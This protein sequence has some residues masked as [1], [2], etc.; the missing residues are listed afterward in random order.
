MTLYSNITNNYSSRMLR[1]QLM[2]MVDFLDTCRQGAKL[3]EEINKRGMYL[4]EGSEMF[5][6]RDLRETK[7]G[8]LQ[9]FLS[10]QVRRLAEHIK[11]KCVTCSARG[12]VCEICSDDK[13]IYAFEILKASACQGCK[14]FFHRECIK[15]AT[16]CPRCRRL[17]KRH[18]E[19][20]K[21]ISNANSTSGQMF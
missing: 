6:M 19:S 8:Q 17:R 18:A 20:K 16:E 15:Q 2:R 4:M 21:L 10:G 1:L 12:F 5:S 3:R 13:P 14:A 7:S 9:R 11:F